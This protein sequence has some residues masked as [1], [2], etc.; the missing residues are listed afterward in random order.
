MNIKID[1]RF[2]QY[3]RG[4][5]GIFI[6]RLNDE[7]EEQC[8]YVGKSEQLKVRAHQHKKSIINGTHISSLNSVKDESD[9]QIE[10]RLIEPVK[11]KFDNYYK[12]AQRLSSRENYWIDEYQKKDQCLE[13]V[14]EG[15]RLSIEWWEKRKKELDKKQ[16]TSLYEG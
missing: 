12:D 7:L 1:N 3:D 16:R 15:K 5:Y 13:Q 6:L 2:E 8:V 9:V 14:P 4:V 10:I 11:Y